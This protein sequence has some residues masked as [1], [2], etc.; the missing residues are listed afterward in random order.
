MYS[1]V[2]FNK[3]RSTIH[4]WEYI[5][6]IRVYSKFDAPIYFYADDKEGDYT[7]IFG[8]K[9]GKVECSNYADLREKADTYRD[10]GKKVFESDVPIETKFIIDRYLGKDLGIPK[11]NIH[12]ID[13]EVHSEEG[14][15]KPSEADYPITI[16]TIWSTKH[17]KYYIFSEKDFEVDFLQGEETCDKMIF[18]SEEDLLKYFVKWFY[19]NS[20]DILSGWN[21]NSFD[22]PYIVNR[23]NKLLGEKWVKRLS[24][25]GIV[26]EIES[27]VGKGQS[28]RTETRYVIAGINCLDMLEVYKNY[29][30]SDRENYKLGYIAEMEIGATKVAYEGTL[31]DLYKDWQN[32]VRYNIQDVRLLRD[33]ENKLGYINLLLTFCYGCRVPFDQF[34]KTTRV[35]DGAFISE[36]SKNKII[37]PDVNRGIRDVKYPGGFVEDPQR[38]VHDWIVSYDATSLYPS[39]MMGW[40]ISPETKVAVLN[41]EYI[42]AVVRAMMEKSYNDMTFELKSGVTFDLDSIGRNTSTIF[43]WI[44]TNPNNS[45]K[46]VNEKGGIHGIFNEIFVDNIRSILS[47][48]EVESLDV[49]WNDEK[50]TTSEVATRIKDN[51][52]CMSAN[53]VIYDQ[54]KQ[55]IVPKFVEEWF[56]KRKEY[57]KKMIVSQI[58]GD[59]EKE[60]YYNL[61]QLNYKILIN[62]VYGYLGTCYSRFYDYDNA[63]AVTMNGQFIIRESSKTI[64]DYFSNWETTELAKKLKASNC[65]H[66]ITYNDTDSCYFSMGK[67][68]NSIK[69]IDWAKYNDEQV[70]NFIMFGKFLKNSDVYTEKLEKEKKIYDLK[71]EFKGVEESCKSIQNLVGGLIKGSMDKLTTKSFNCS[72]NKIYFKREGIS[73]R[74]AFLKKKRYVMWVLNNEG[75]E[76]DKI[77]CVGVEIVRSSTPLIIQDVLEDIVLTMLKTVD[78]SSIVK[79]IKE[80]KIEFMKAS[81]EK[82]AFPRG[83]HEL[84]LYT[85]AWNSGKRTGTPINARA[86]ILY[87]NWIL[88]DKKLKAQ[89]DVIHSDSKM[90]FLYIKPNSVYVEDIIGFVDILPKEFNLHD[91]I[92]K[93]LQFE[94]TFINPLTAIF[95][96]F[97]WTFPNLINEDISDLFVY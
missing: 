26:N 9:A 64:N 85:D 31:I 4:L 82:I 72:T 18:S 25:I 28:M 38:G 36:L 74:V 89:Y 66:V 70:K 77:K 84:D 67:V 76:T 62:A 33:L 15:P 75:V 11:F 48:K 42:D 63:S 53:G 88:S 92:D 52:F 19:E 60:R 71:P 1:A 46:D 10:M 73:R 20:P 78:Y 65:E 94:K 37:L 83:I 87:N 93:E 34:N 2:Y 68:I 47:G 40:N 12:F 5:D 32:Y 27:K 95:E 23:I 39:I 3:S 50:T 57:K 43:E 29:T 90:K 14:F 80:F 6:G 49:F 35:L 41:V 16:I 58:A 55:G 22:I 61:L 17:N 54:R 81:P 97:G 8:D 59:K 91:S 45:L 86:A 56:N 30:F 51:G 96:V 69:G 13:I 21:S 79:R 7:S 44:S 24:P